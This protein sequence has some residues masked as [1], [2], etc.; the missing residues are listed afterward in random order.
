MNQTTLK[1]FAQA[2]RRELLKQVALRL[3]YWIGGEGAKSRVDSAEHRQFAPQVKELE[4]AVRLEGREALIE[5]VAYT[6]F[7]RLAALRFMD[8]NGYHPFGAKVVMPATGSETLPEILQQARAGVMDGEVR[9]CLANAKAFDDILAGRIPVGHLEQAVYRLILVAVCNYYQRLMPFMFEKIGDA[10]ELLLPEDLLTE[11]S[12][13]NAFR[14]ELADDDCRDVEVIGWLY[15][16]YISEKKDAVMGRNAAVP[17]EDI[18]AVTQ[19]FTPHWIVRYLVENSLGRLWLQ[20]RPQSRLQEK[21]PYYVSAPAPEPQAWEPAWAD[22]GIDFTEGDYRT[23]LWLR[24][25][26]ALADDY[27]A[28]LRYAMTIDGYAYAR[29]KWGIADDYWPKLEECER[30]GWDNLGF[31]DLRWCLFI[32]Q[33]G[34]KWSDDSDEELMRKYRL[35]YDA[36]CRAWDHEWREHEA[37]MPDLR[38]LGLSGTR[39]DSSGDI[40]LTGPEDIRLMDPACGSG[41]MLTYA[42]DLLYAIYAEEG[43]DE[44]DIPGLILKHNLYGVEICDR[45]AALAAFALYMKARASDRRFFRRVVQPNVVS[46]QD[47]RF[48][49]GE[50]SA[51][52]KAIGM[53]PS[54]LHPDFL[55]LLHQF[56]NAKNFGS[57]IQPCLDERAVASA[58]RAIAGKNL[59]E[60]L[61]LRETHIRIQMVLEQA[62]TLTQRY[63]VVVANP[64]YMGRGGMNVT[65]RDFVDELFPNS[66]HNL[67]SVFMERLGMLAI[68]AGAVAM[69]T[70]QNWMFLSRFSAFRAVLRNWRL[71]S[72]LHLGARAF[73][74]ISGEVVQTAAFIFWT[75]PHQ[76]KPT[77]FFRLV[78]GDDSESKERAFLT[79]VRDAASPLRFDVATAR[80]RVIQEEP[81]CYWATDREFVLFEKYPVLGKQLTAREGMATGSNGLFLRLWHEVASNHVACGCSSIPESVQS[82][83]KWFPYNKGGGELRWFGNNDYFVNWQN[84]G[85]EIRG[86]AD[87]RTG[88]IR[89]HNYNGEYSFREGVS[90]SSIGSGRLSARYSPVGFLFDAKGTTAFAPSKLMFFT[91]LLNSVVGTRFISL[92]SP[93]LDFKLGHVLSVPVVESQETILSV[94]ALV[95]LSI[96]L[97]RVDWDNLET[98]WDFRDLPVLRSGQWTVGGGQPG[99]YWKGATLEESWNNWKSYCD[100]AIRR[101]QELETENNRL[102][103]DAYGLQDELKP[104]VPEEQITLARADARKD[105][106]AFVSYAVGCMFGRYSLDAPGLILADAG[107]TVA[108]YLAEV[109]KPTFAPDSDGILP[110]LD[111]EWF[112]DD[113]VARF[114]EF[115]KATFGEAKL[116]E[117][118]AFVEASLEKDLRKYFVR[119]FYKNHLSNERAYGYKKRPIYWMVS[120][121][122][123]SFQAL[124]YLHRYTRDT[125]HLLLNDY[126]REFIHKLEER[127]RQQTAIRLNESARAGDRTKAVKELGKIEKM[128]KE[129]RQWEHDILLPLAQQRVE[130]D[131]DD[132]VKVNYLKFKGVLAPIPGLEMKDEE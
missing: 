5:R 39:A 22:K 56:E 107:A 88:R 77:H 106:A 3:N 102:F 83:R 128:L 71:D 45:A 35:I 127:Q 48:D 103:I 108:D 36:V 119:D 17:K 18:P 112:A 87:E 24:P 129:L 25:N 34:I 130:I 69:V 125:M 4:A 73:D 55:K 123:G 89:S 32:V 78:D 65:L 9:G 31:A 54:D 28:N 51:Y 96:S 19:L 132:G 105:M 61:F 1:N 43:Y 20:N 13:L 53:Q 82:G 23:F 101:M 62:E 98:S 91:G 30:T 72:L 27:H 16:Y 126:V 66:K 68:T 8:A 41:H 81:F 47:V 59:G 104:E 100:A 94:G 131:L 52:F 2:A 10:T 92:L 93:T 90:W 57:L 70:M 124:I 120:S 114:R 109:P 117:N 76:E 116:D 99:G 6:W 38:Q 58:R 86:F 64:P 63:H 110:V 122:E 84:D 95:E 121:P 42:Y 49:E 46:L 97:A 80:F 12:I 26:A 7:N 44:K 111:G 67:F 74:S 115:L 50:L 21:M 118:L 79:S 15:Q 37:E 11:H 75:K 14:T 60:Q 33:R 29:A 40:R 113:I 85:A